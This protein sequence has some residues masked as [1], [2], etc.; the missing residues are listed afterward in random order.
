M[1]RMRQVARLRE[2][3]VPDWLEE[4]VRPAPAPL[5]WAAMIRAAG[6]ICGPM[7]VATVTGQRSLSV[8]AIGGL[9][10]T[11]ADRG[12]SYAARVR[13]AGS[14]CVFG[15]AVGLAIGSLIHGRGWIAV[16]A[17]VC[18][19]G[20]SALLSAISDTGSVTGLMLLVYSA[21][22]LGPFGAVR[23]WWH[24]PIGLLLGALWAFALTVPG[25]LRSPHAAEQ[26]R[27]ADVYRA[28]AAALNAIGT[29]RAAQ[30]RHEL[31]A[32][33][34]D[35]YDT[36]LTTRSTISGRN[37]RLVRLMALLNEANVIVEA[38]TVLSREGNSAPR[39]VVRAVGNMADAIGRGRGTVVIPGPWGSS[40]GAVALKDAL[41]GA[42]SL[43]AGRLMPPAASPAARRLLRGR[44]GAVRD[45]V[46][47]EFSWTF[48]VRLMSSVGVAAVLS[49]VLPL[50]R[51][52][53]LVLTVALVLKPDFG[54]VF[55]RAL[56]R[57]I[58]TIVGAVLGAVILILVPYGP[59]LLIPFG[60]LAALGPYGQKRNYGLYTTFLTPLV[61]LLIDL[62][63]PIGWHL[64]LD[65]LIDTL[66]G[67]V[68]VLVVGYAPWPMSWH[69]D[70]PSQFALTIGYICRYMDAALVT[71]PS[72]AAGATGSARRAGT[73]LPARTRLR[74]QASRAVSNLR[75]DFQR[76]MAEP[77]AVSRGATAW[78][79]ALV[80]LEEVVDEVTA[81]SVAI[82][83]GAPA[84]SPRAVR[85]LCGALGTLAS[86]IA[87]GGSSVAPELPADEPLKPVTEA[88]RSVFTVLG[89]Q[90]PPALAGR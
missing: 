34:N 7:A 46:S 39:M 12:G 57:G 28:I 59:W 76:M 83:S 61:V 81:T 86:E 74:R 40:Q 8:L 16:L 6:A 20:A 64:A 60:V 82:A 58:G 75:A 14:A 54:S 5:P 48:A 43:M 36:L 49:E 56:Q 44:A 69:A 65:R 3:V 50:Y 38:G 80:G 13:R 24:S 90:R 51:S 29:P 18:V 26:R 47:S 35:A 66:V 85:Q 4:V 31:T 67:C 25:W 62:L 23:P 55:A 70:L 15:G 2:A 78:W 27:V 84:A 88:V 10:W 22:G 63:V 17:L 79:P 71:M 1:A 68:V 32:A 42:A 33:L 53:W 41:D 45:R 19:A 30:V 89:R 87:G 21:L 11:S 72:S 37:S 52:Y 77:P 9:V 73:E